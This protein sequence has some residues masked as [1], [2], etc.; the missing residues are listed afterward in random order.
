M[1]FVI[2]GRKALI[3]GKQLL[4]QLLSGFIQ[5]DVVILAGKQRIADLIFPVR[6]CFYRKAMQSYVFFLPLWQCYWFAPAE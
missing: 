4:I 1:D 5:A 6:Q 2:N 3:N